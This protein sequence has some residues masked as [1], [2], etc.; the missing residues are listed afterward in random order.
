MAILDSL[1]S[2]RKNSDR[3]RTSSAE[4]LIKNDPAQ[5]LG[6]L[7]VEMDNAKQKNQTPLYNGFLKIAGDARTGGAESIARR[8]MQN[9]GIVEK[10]YGLDLAVNNNFTGLSEEIKTLAADRNE[11]LARKARRTAEKLG[12]TVD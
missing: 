9:G 11:S 12:I 3:V 2:E 4:M 8:L 1:F 10:S 6:R 7:I 5:Y